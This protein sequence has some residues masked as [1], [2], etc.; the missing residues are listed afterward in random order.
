MSG[1]F[2]DVWATATTDGS[3]DRAKD[4]YSVLRKETMSQDRAET[5]GGNLFKSVWKGRKPV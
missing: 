3:R 4:F 5:K 1:P 2:K